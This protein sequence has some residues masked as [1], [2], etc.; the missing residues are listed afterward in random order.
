MKG[1]RVTEAVRLSMSPRVKI[2]VIPM[3][4]AIVPLMMMDQIMALGKVSEASW[5][6]SDICTEQS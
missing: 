2:K 4:K 6:S 3:T 5:I 1:C